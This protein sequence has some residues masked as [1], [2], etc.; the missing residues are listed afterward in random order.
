[1]TKLKFPP[2]RM[3]DFGMLDAAEEARERPDMLKTGYYDFR[4]AAYRVAQGEA[5]AI[6]GSKGAGKTATFSHLELLWESQPERFL[7]EWDLGSFPVAD[8]TQ[9]QIGGSPGPTNTRAAWEFLILL[10]VFASL[11]KDQ[12]AHHPSGIVGL[13][14]S[15]V[16]GGLIDGPDLRTR[17]V[18][19]SRSTLKV[20]IMG[21]GVDAALQQNSVT[22]VQLSQLLRS[23][24]MQMRSGSQHVL[25][26]DGLD[27]FFAQTESQLES[28]GAL[29]DAAYD[30]NG[31]FRSADLR[32]SIVLAIRHDMYVQV[33][34]TDSAKLSDRAIELDWS[35]NGLGDGEELWDLLNTKVRASIPGSFVGLQ[36]GDVRKAYLSSPIGIGPFSYLPSY[37]MSHTRYL[38]RDLIA[39]M[40]AVKERHPGSGQVSESTAREAVRNYSEGY[41]VR[42]ISNG[43]SRVLPGA[44][45]AKVSTFLD[46]LSALPSREFSFELLEREVDGD[47][48]RADLRRLM[49]QL[50]L[51][52]GVGT[53]PRAAR[54]THTNF[55]YRRVAGGGF[56]FHA[57][58]VLHNSLVVAWNVPWEALKKP[59]QRA[60]QSTNGRRRR[61]R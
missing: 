51:I 2:L 47:I 35:R 5:W 7:L 37:L 38:P 59:S 23:A 15:L 56:S 50:F 3:L 19:W 40:N 31:F 11:M 13:Y 22:P 34:S 14:K 55:Y 41:F 53:K 57:D 24:L 44:S 43:L 36:L 60:E 46:A 6:V 25:A 17:F 8:V 45:A 18:D 32:V 48:S 58:Y 28:L 1:M 61:R 9:L 12:G 4:S 16:A 21:S 29:L 33:P 27:S 52:G 26:I 42:E 39:L 20:S 54:S 30:L 49:K 10:R